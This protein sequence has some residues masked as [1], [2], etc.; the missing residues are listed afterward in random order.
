MA[1]NFS[2]NGISNTT[3]LKKTNIKVFF[4]YVMEFGERD[5]DHIVNLKVIVN[6][7]TTPVSTAKQ[8]QVVFS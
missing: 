5:P 6:I 3:R 8:A 1:S 4:Q 2:W 7:S